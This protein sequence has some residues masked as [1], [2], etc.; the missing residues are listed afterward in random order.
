MDFWVE[1]SW[2]AGAF[3]LA[4]YLATRLLPKKTR[5]IVWIICLLLC[6]SGTILL[7]EKSRLRNDLFKGG[8]YTQYLLERQELYKQGY[9]IPYINGLGE[10]P[11]VKHFFYRGEKYKKEFKFKEAIEEFKKCL[12]HPEATEKNKVAANILIGNCYHRLFKLKEAEKHY[13][14]ALNISTRVK[15]RNERPKGRLSA[16]NY[17]GLIY[18]DSGRFGIGKRNK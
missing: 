9:L 3:L 8:D 17:T 18:R 15:D 12:F 7:I 10:N 2:I 14:E 13:Q 5:I 6:I 11:L 16:I 1:Y 4:I